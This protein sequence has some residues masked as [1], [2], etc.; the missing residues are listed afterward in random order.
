MALVKFMMGSSS[1]GGFVMEAQSLHALIPSSFCVSKSIE[2][3]FEIAYSS[4]TGV[5]IISLKKCGPLVV[6]KVEKEE[7]A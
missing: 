6:N 4:I 3:Q 7:K 2:H 1:I 5:V